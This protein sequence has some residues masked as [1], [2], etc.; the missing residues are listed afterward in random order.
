M[1][2]TTIGITGVFLFAMT[3]ILITV[4]RRTFRARRP[5]GPSRNGATGP[6]LSHEALIAQYEQANRLGR[7]EQLTVLEDPCEHPNVLF[8][9][10]E[11]SLDDEEGVPHRITWTGV[12]QCDF[13]HVLSGR[14]TRIV[15]RCHV[16][17]A[18]LCN[19]TKSCALY[20]VYCGRAVGRCHAHIKH[21][22]HADGQREYEVYCTNCR[23]TR[24]L[25]YWFGI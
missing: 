16:C 4:L 6:G 13:G 25:D 15:A 24:F 7:T 18:R 19:T 9:R 5:D 17:S 8:H 12:T 1:H 14:E 20:C 10:E 3:V 21:K 11:L 23:W 2:G 22:S